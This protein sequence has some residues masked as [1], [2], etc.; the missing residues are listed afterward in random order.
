[1]FAKANNNQKIYVGIVVSLQ[2]I[3]LLGICGLFMSITVQKRHNHSHITN[4]L[5]IR[6]TLDAAE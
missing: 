1:M 5:F 3:I 2:N 6:L 4:L